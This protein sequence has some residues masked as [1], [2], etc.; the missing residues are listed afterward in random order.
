MESP[1][2]LSVKAEPTLVDVRD[3]I[4]AVRPSPATASASTATQPQPERVASGPPALFSAQ[5]SVAVSSVPPSARAAR[6]PAKIL[7]SAGHPSPAPSKAPASAT[8]PTPAT[9]K[10]AVPVAHVTPAPVV[11]AVTNVQPPVTVP[12]DA[13][14]RPAPQPVAPP[15]RTPAQPRLPTTPVRFAA[16]LAHRPAPA[17]AP[18]PATTPQLSA[19]DPPPASP[20]K[21]ALGQLPSRTTSQSSIAD[22]DMLPGLAGLDVEAH[23]FPIL[24]EAMKDVKIT[25]VLFLSLRIAGPLCFSVLLIVLSGGRFPLSRLNVMVF[26]THPNRWPS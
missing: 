22:P 6:A 14:A 9:A 15:L 16:A 7:A 5:P 20:L 25:K 12:A 18:I 11:A 10:A 4:P 13:P 2:P 1:L 26:D 23:E 21:A 8:H 17:Q 3:E 19:G 24:A